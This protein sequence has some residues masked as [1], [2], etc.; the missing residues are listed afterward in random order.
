[1]R[2]ITD[3]Q[4]EFAKEAKRKFPA[5]AKWSQKDRL[6]SIDRQLAD[7]GGALQ[8]EEGIYNHDNHAYENPNHRIAATIADLLLLVDSRNFNLDEEL[9]K[10]L[11]WY[12]S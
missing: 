3:W 10:V 1:M 5:N 12:K 9:D 11:D 8:K 2:T 7:V 4:K 6:L